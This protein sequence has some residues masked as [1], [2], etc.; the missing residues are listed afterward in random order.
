MDVEHTIPLLLPGGK[1]NTP[2]SLG[3]YLEDVP[4][5][6][7]YDDVKCERPIEEEENLDETPVASSLWGSLTGGSSIF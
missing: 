5:Y 3:H 6:C 1:L 4:F 7:L 2:T